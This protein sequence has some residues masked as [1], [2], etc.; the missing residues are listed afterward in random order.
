MF[1][2]GGKLNSAQDSI[3]VWKVCWP[4]EHNEGKYTPRSHEITS[5]LLLLT[6][7]TVQQRGQLELIHGV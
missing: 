3:I 1:I 7:A 5:V 2:H 6:A 4:M